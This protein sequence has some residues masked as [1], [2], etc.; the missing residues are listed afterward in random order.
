M[1]IHIYLFGA[2]GQAEITDE[3]ADPGKTRKKRPSNECAV[4]VLSHLV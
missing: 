3:V 2:S 1:H 4:S